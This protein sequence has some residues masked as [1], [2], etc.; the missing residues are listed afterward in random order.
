MTLV[1]C[2]RVLLLPS[3]ITGGTSATEANRP[4]PSLK[5]SLSLG[6]SALAGEA[7]DRERVERS[8]GS[9]NENGAP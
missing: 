1:A 4:A 9:P 6:A 8:E 2:C 5:I 3:D 7:N